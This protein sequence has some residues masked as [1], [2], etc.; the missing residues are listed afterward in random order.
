MDSYGTNTTNRC[1]MHLDRAAVASCPGCGEYFCKECLGQSGYCPACSS[2]AERFLEGFSGAL[3]R[4]EAKLHNPEVRNYG[5]PPSRGK[6]LSLPR[7]I[8]VL[9]LVGVGYSSLHFIANY[10]LYLGEMFLNQGNLLKAQHHLEQAADDEPENA[11]LQYILGNIY[12]RQGNMNDAV[13][14]YRVCLGLDSLNTSAM[15][16]LA[17]TYTQLSVNLNEA[18]ALSKNSVEIEPDNANYLDTLA[19]IYYLKKEYYRALTYIRK[20]VDLNPPNIEYY[21]RKMEKIK[22]LAYGQGRPLE[23]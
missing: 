4:W 12:S 22:K 8:A 6:I 7:I 19:E 23:V 17:W 21:R 10:H 2:T 3:A 14:A 13:L 15:N 9:L 16:N 11:N 1:S 5:N 18:L 20:A